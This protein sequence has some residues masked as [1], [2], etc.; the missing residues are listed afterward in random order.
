M[1]ACNID[2]KGVTKRA[3]LGVVILAV[4]LGLAAWLLLAADSRW[5]RLMTWPCFFLAALCLLQAQEKV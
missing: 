2:H 5:A 1:N 4:A 3:V